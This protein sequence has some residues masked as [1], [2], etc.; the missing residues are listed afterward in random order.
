MALPN[1][2]NRISHEAPV[3]RNVTYMERIGKAIFF[4]SCLIGSKPLAASWL[5]SAAQA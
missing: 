5:M 3:T 2:F 1:M 4:G